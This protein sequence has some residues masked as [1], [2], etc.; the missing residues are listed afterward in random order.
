MI[1]LFDKLSR[2]IRNR[3]RMVLLRRL[4]RKVRQNRK[5]LLPSYYTFTNSFFMEMGLITPNDLLRP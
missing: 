4:R 3:L 5:T 2:W 1:T